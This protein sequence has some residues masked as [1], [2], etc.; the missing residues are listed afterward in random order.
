MGDTDRRPRRD[1]RF[2]MINLAL[3]LVAGL[4]GFALFYFTHIA[5]AWGSILPGFVAAV[6]AYVLLARRTMKQLEAVMASA[7][8][9]LAGQRIE[10]AGAILEGA[11]PLAGLQFLV[12][13]QLP[14]QIRALP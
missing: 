14:R 4:A 2:L 5:P 12:A 9:E 10:K 3:A 8:K 11:F 13:A 7:Q 1:W 6:V